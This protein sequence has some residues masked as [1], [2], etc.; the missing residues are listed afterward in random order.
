MA[1]KSFLVIVRE[2]KVY[3]FVGFVKNSLSM[4]ATVSMLAFGMI[5]FPGG[6][7][8]AGA[9]SHGQDVLRWGSDY[10]LTCYQ[11]NQ[12][13]VGVSYVAQVQLLPL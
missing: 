4:A 1:S 8:K 2:S 11:G 10:L 13:S 6:F 9:I 12:T 7:Q 5:Q 3:L